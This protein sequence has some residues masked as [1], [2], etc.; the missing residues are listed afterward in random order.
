VVGAVAGGVLLFILTGLN[1]ASDV[2]AHTGGF[3]GGMALGTALAWV[4]ESWLSRAWLSGV[5]GIIALLLLA[6]AWGMAL[7]A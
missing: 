5:C 2:V 6:T 1:P 3:L 7:S 4:P